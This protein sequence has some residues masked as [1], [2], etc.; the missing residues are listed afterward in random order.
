M[1][2]SCN[3]VIDFHFLKF[4]TLYSPRPGIATLSLNALGDLFI[5][6][7]ARTR[8]TRSNYMGF[9][10]PSCGLEPA[11]DIIRRRGSRPFM[12]EFYVLE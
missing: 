1:E 3:F 9:G 11:L 5:W 7:T 6:P 2:V 4:D 8:S 10:R 12:D